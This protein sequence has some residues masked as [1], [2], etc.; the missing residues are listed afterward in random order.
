MKEDWEQMK[1]RKNK[2][3]CCDFVA[4]QVTLLLTAGAKGKRRRKPFRIS[5]VAGLFWPRVS[6]APPLSL[7]F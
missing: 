6:D 2:A 4:L 3:G 5:P 1:K 7:Q